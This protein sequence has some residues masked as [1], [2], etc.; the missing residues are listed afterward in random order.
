MGVLVILVASFGCGALLSAQPAVNAALARHLGSPYAATIVSLLV[1]TALV[2]PFAIATASRLRLEA[3]G[4]APWW[5]W[6]G[7]VAG[8]AMV[9]AGLVFAPRIGVTLF[10]MTVVAGQLVAAA[11]IDQYGLFGVE[12]RGID[13]S[14]LAGIALVACGLLVYLSG[15]R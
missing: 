4:G 2:A 3:L 5:A 7:G 13:A 12:V 1:S 10:I 9:S 15:D 6:L 11:L 8:A 14:R